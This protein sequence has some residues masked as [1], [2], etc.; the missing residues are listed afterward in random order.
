MIDGHKTAKNYR[1]RTKLVF[2][3]PHTSLR[4]ARQLAKASKK[5]PVSSRRLV[6]G[7]HNSPSRHTHTCRIS[8]PTSACEPGG[9]AW[10]MSRIMGISSCWCTRSLSPAALLGPCIYSYCSMF[11]VSRNPW[12]APNDQTYNGMLIKLDCFIG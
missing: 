12:S 2:E 8:T 7:G 10:P 3:T 1:R 4:D 6:C 11:S 9:T 5:R